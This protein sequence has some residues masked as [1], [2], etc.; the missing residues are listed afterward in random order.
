MMWILDISQTFISKVPTQTTNNISYKYANAFIVLCFG[1]GHIVRPC[2]LIYFPDSKVY[3]ADMGPTW[4]PQ[5]PGG[6]HVG[7]INLAIWVIFLSVTSRAQGHL[8]SRLSSLEVILKDMDKFYG[9][10]T[11]CNKAWSICVSRHVIVSKQT[12]TKTIIYRWLSARLQCFQCIMDGHTAVLHKVTDMWYSRQQVSTHCGHVVPYGVAYLDQLWIRQWL[13]AWLHQ[14]NALSHDIK[15]VVNKIC[16]NT[17]RYIIKR[18]SAFVVHQNSNIIFGNENDF[19]GPVNQL[20]ESGWR[21]CA[22]V[23]FL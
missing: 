21:K 22:S 1:V 8:Y 20:N 19:A 13:V 23:I 18:I 4:G 3:V 16:R 17:P 6:P 7:P 14:A 5:D 2:G 10:T 11:E 9:T 15:C 12:T